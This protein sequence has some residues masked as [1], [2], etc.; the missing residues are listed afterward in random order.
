MIPFILN[1][2]GSLIYIFAL[3]ST[4]LSIAV[5]IANSLTFVFTALTAHFIGEN[6]ATKSKFF[7]L[8]LQRKGKFNFYFLSFILFL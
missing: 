6:S 4:N 1:Q 7:F 3:Q 8:F 2:L 5:P